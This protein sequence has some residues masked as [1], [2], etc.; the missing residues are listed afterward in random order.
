MRSFSC[1][2][3]PNDDSL[4]QT[5]LEKLQSDGQPRPDKCNA[6]SR[7]GKK[8][9]TNEYDSSRVNSSPAAAGDQG[10]EG[11]EGPV[12]ED[13][14]PAG[15]AP[16]AEGKGPMLALWL[17]FQLPSSCYATMLIRV[18]NAASRSSLAFGYRHRM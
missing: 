2:S 6:M 16:H 15:L 13:S 11:H 3:D 17:K 18:R 1:H 9:R 14:E 7:D 4:I 8:I 5:D 12:K 10:S